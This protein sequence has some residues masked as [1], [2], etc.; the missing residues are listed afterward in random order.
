MKSRMRVIAGNAHGR[1]LRVPRGSAT[2]P[3]S[4]RVRESIFSRL[5]AR[6]ELDG[7]RVLDLFAGSGALGIEAL[8][9]G[10]GHAVFIDSSRAAA[11]AISHNLAALGL[12]GRAEILT[13]E[14]GRALQALAARGERF[15][16]VLMDAP[17]QAGES[18]P[19]MARL[20][21]LNLL[22]EGAYLAMELSSREGVPEAPGGLESVSVATMG[23]HRIALYR[24]SG[25]APK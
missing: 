2:R 21:E 11:S 19:A 23:D 22:A 15:A 25:A 18:A 1:W 9:R 10:A 17:Y 16:L 20:V 8:S 13:L 6:I 4:A 24:R 5:C 3:T 14:A 12:G 7:L